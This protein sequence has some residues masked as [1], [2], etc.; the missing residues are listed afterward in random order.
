MKERKKE[1]KEEKK[2]RK[3]GPGLITGVSIPQRVSIIFLYIY[4]F[5]NHL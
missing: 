1:R 5:M 2:E 3:N 4:I